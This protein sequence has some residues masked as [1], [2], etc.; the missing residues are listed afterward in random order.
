[1]LNFLRRFFESPEASALRKLGE[2]NK[3]IDASGGA[4]GFLRATLESD[5]YR[6][7]QHK[8]IL[9][10]GVVAVDDNLAVD[11]R[12]A[13]LR[14]LHSFRHKAQ[15]EGSMEMTN[16]E[17]QAI[18]ELSL[19]RR[20]FVDG[21]LLIDSAAL[22]EVDASEE[23]KA[24]A[25]GKAAQ[26]VDNARIKIAQHMLVNLLD[27]MDVSRTVDLDIEKLK[28]QVDDPAVSYFCNRAI[29][30]AEEAN[31][32]FEKWQETDLSTLEQMIGLR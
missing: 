11:I 24:L 14:V 31:N 3:R 19:A 4:W 32:G 28:L 27:T 10:C 5:D 29:R 6:S 1:M 13:A 23:F 15:N 26:A 16:V 8:S 2:A 12:L 30:R 22:L 20:M 9:R 21:H 25:L 7:D 18:P 17:I